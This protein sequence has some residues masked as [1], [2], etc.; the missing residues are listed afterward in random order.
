MKSHVR[1]ELYPSKKD[2]AQWRAGSNE[3]TRSAEAWAEAIARNLLTLN[4]GPVDSV[5]VIARS[6]NGHMFTVAEYERD[7]DG[8]IS[9]TSRPLPVA[10][11]IA[12][13]GRGWLHMDDSMGRGPG[14]E[15]CDDCNRYKSDDEAAEAHAKECKCGLKVAEEPVCEARHEGRKGFVYLCERPDGHEGVHAA[16]LGVAGKDAIYWNADE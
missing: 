5:E 4:T 14:I 6:P 1:I 12:C 10:D 15:A 3:T 2:F 11:C 8:A 9:D 7:A 13:E 16:R